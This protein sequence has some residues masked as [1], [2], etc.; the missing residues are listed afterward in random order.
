MELKK[1]TIKERIAYLF[2]KYMDG[3]ITFEMFRIHMSG[4]HIDE[5]ET[6]HKQVS[7]LAEFIMMEVD[8]EPSKSEGAIDTAIRL[9][10][11]LPEHKTKEEKKTLSDK[12]FVQSNTYQSKLLAVDVIEALKEFI[13]KASDNTAVETKH[14][15]LAKE[16]FGERLI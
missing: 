13:L 16:I 9:L 5:E 14:I 12:I 7:R 4:I 15:K 10:K 11:K 8:G 3:E 6:S 1:R 2:G